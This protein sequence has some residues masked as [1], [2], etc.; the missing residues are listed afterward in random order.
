MSAKKIVSPADKKKAALKDKIKAVNEN[1][2]NTCKLVKEK[3]AVKVDGLKLK[4]EA[5]KKAMVQKAA[6]K[7]A[8][9]KKAAADSKKKATAP[10]KAAAAPKKKAMPKQKWIAPF[11]Q[12]QLE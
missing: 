9:A 6:A 1:A 2:K 5:M 10:K 11:A 7:K 8:A 4:M 3:A 12:Y